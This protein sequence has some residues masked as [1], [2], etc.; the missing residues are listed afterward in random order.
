MHSRGE[1]ID[2]QQ[3]ASATVEQQQ[4]LQQAS[5]QAVQ[6]FMLYA[7]RRMPSV[8]LQSYLDL[9]RQPPLQAL[10]QASQEELLQL[11]RERRSELLH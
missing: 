7:Y 6:G 5:Q 4:R 3:L 1:S 11:F 8:Q 9:Y 10:L 2:E